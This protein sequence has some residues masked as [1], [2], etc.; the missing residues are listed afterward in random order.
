MFYRTDEVSHSQRSE[1]GVDARL[2]LLQRTRGS[3]P[4]HHR[5]QCLRENLPTRLGL[6]QHP[7]RLFLPSIPPTHCIVFS[8]PF[9]TSFYYF[10]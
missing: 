5:A 10:F 8:F 6:V 3:L 2:V 1:Q 9:F 7:V 4:Q